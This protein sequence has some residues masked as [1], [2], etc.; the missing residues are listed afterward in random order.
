MSNK[1][2]IKNIIFIL[3]KIEMSYKIEYTFN[4]NSG[5]IQIVLFINWQQQ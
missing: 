5:L 2:A 3:D 4:V 1:D